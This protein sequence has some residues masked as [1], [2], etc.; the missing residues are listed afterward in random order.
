[1]SDDRGL[2]VLLVEDD[3]G[4]RWIMSEIL[5]SR[6]HR[7]TA[8]ETAEIGWDRFQDVPHPL[9]LL[10]WLL[11]G[12]DGLELCRR[13][14]KHPR[15][16]ESVIVVVTSRDEPEDLEEV[17]RA[18]ADDYVTKPI[19]VGLLN[20]RLAVA[21]NEVQDVRARKRT[22]AELE[23]RSRELRTLFQNLDEIFFT[24]DLKRE[25]LVQVSPGAERILGRSAE[26]LEAD[27]ELRRRLL[28]PRKLEEELA[29]TPP[30][31]AASVSRQYRIDRPDGQT[32]WLEST[33]KATRDDQGRLERVD[34]SVSDVT[35][36]KRAQRELSARNE[37]LRTLYRISEI[38]L[39]AGS[40]DET[41][42]EILE[43]I[44]RATGY[45][46]VAV[47]RYDPDRQRMVI[48]A[49]LGLPLDDHEDPSIPVNET[50]SGV[51]VQDRA[52]VVEPDVRTREEYRPELFRKAGIRSY[53]AVPMFVSGRVVGTLTL[54]HTEAADPDS[55]LVRWAGSLANSVATLV[56]RVAAQEA[57]VE[58]ERQHRT[59][60][61]RLR[62]ANEELE[63]FAYSISHDLRTPL[64][65]MQ[66]FAHALLDDY[67]DG[68]E[69]GAR[70]YL[71]RIIESGER[72]ERLIADLLAY[73]RLSF[74]EVQLQPVELEEVVEAAREQLAGD[75]EEAG[76]RL[77]VQEDLPRVRGHRA[78][79]VQVVSNLLSNAVKFVPPERTP[80]VEI[81]AEEMD[82][83]VRLWVQD[84]GVGVSPDKTERIFR[85]FE[86]LATSGDRPGTGIG[87]A[88]VRRGMERLGGR[89]GVDS[90]PGRG[91]RFWIQIPRTSRPERQTGERTRTE[92]PEA[93]SG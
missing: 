54:A 65:T 81:G 41:Y 6:G 77:Q 75:L 29:S 84:N 20:I 91:S 46:M 11:P 73:S 71:R 86:R 14:R 33:L 80:E 32:R 82:E 28:F 92:G 38:V 63:A 60:A 19:D 40:L 45:P 4:E 79:L 34:G 50:L 59:L 78:T 42:E 31:E 83:G 43:E 55:R 93:A 67:G 72:S 5:R 68:L 18:G 89:F 57:L 26:E 36:E 2:Q 76:A 1:M 35:R 49:A 61:R 87:L 22:Q 64:R 70:D 74:E 88:I 39:G 69:P 15:G 90:D 51:A 52:P 27:P 12:M 47:E 24:L 17:L 23:A 13:I 10:D 21:E 53:V 9:I 37:E 16:D 62:Q 3:P 56:D 85:V 66:G 7:V 48:R 30:D 58:S 8:C 25:A 44:R